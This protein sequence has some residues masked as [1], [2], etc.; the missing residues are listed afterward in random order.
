MV[1]KRIIKNLSR[2]EIMKMGV[3]LFPGFF[4]VDKPFFARCAANTAKVINEKI[5]PGRRKKV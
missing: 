5:N 4:M 2:A 3:L 1:G